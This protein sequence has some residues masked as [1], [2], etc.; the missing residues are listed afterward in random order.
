MQAYFSAGSIFP[1]NVQVGEADE[2]HSHLYNIHIQEAVRMQ[3]IHD[4]TFVTWTA[5]YKWTKYQISMAIMVDQTDDVYTL[6]KIND[7][8]TLLKIILCCWKV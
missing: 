5:T 3:G 7:S 6:R 8:D 4:S 1:P 2:F